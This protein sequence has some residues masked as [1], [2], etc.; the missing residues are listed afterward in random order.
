MLISRDNNP[1][2]D[3]KPRRLRPF[4]IVTDNSSALTLNGTNTRQGTLFNAGSP[5]IGRTFRRVA[6]VLRIALGAPGPFAFVLRDGA[7][8]VLWQSPDISGTVLATTFRSIAVNTSPRI[9]PSG[10][11]LLIEGTVD[12]SN[13]IPVGRAG[14]NVLDANTI[15]TTYTSGAYSTSGTR[16][17]AFTLW[18]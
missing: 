4:L 16:T 8:A 6:C 18:E 11:R 7:D 9:I 15:S 14:T 17:T 2:A 12:A 10:S 3:A 13:T 1:F 5:Y